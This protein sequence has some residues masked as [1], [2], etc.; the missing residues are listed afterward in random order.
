MRYMIWLGALLLPL[1]IFLSIG[2]TAIFVITTYP[3]ILLPRERL[4]RLRRQLIIVWARGNQIIFGFWVSVKNMPNLP[5]LQG[6]VLFVGNHVSYWEVF[7]I[8]T[9]LPKS[10][11]A[12]AELR[13]IPL[14]GDG[15]KV[16]GLL[17][18]ERSNM[19]SRVAMIETVKSALV[20]NEPLM[21]FPEGTT[22]SEPKILPFHVGG[23]KAAID[24]TEAG[25]TVHIVPVGISYARFYDHAWG[26]QNG[27]AHFLRSAA[28]LWH[29]AALVFGEPIHVRAG[30]ARELSE[31]ARTEC[32]RLF[33][34]ARQITGP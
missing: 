12:K 24:A 17:F 29:H 3:L 21:I 16:L 8:A 22:A 32:E 10:Y 28:L 6:G 25:Q 1:R 34:V 15:A 5:A 2:Y 18:V 14:I 13:K 11:V 7:T 23:F 33:E 4:L 30:D 31:H 27:I 20:R 9:R 19:G 26:P